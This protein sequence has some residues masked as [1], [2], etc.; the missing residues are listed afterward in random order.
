MVFSRVSQLAVYENHKLRTSKKQW[1]CTCTGPETVWSTDK[2]KYWQGYSD[3]IFAKLQELER[4]H[5]VG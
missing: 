1:F 2:D 3:H 5:E 4:R